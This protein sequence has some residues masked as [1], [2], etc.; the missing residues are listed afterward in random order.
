MC[1]LKDFLFDSLVTFA[2]FDCISQL[3]LINVCYV[4]E[5]IQIS[6]RLLHTIPFTS[7]RTVCDLLTNNNLFAIA[8]K[9]TSIYLGTAAHYSDVAEYAFLC[10]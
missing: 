1:A 4:L 3:V 8:V 2:D 9:E 5:N 10:H 6:L 7:L